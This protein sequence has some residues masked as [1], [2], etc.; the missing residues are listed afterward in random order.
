MI[1]IIFLWNNHVYA[2]LVKLRKWSGVLLKQYNRNSS[3]LSYLIAPWHWISL[4]ALFSWPFDITWKNLLNCY[5]P[6]ILN[7][8]SGSKRG[9]CEQRDCSLFLSVCER[10]WTL[11]ILHGGQLVHTLVLHD[12]GLQQR[13][14]VGRVQQHPNRWIASTIIK[15]PSFYFCWSYS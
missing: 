13:W 8:F 9:Q 5:I 14:P 10:T 11:R 3:N 6:I 4:V 15:R 1:Q 2:F 12:S 7:F